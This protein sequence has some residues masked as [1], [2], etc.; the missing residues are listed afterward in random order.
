MYYF[1]HSAFSTLKSYYS[2]HSPRFLQQ[3]EK[4]RIILN[5]F[6][7]SLFVSDYLFDNSKNWHDEV[8]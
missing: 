6:F 4:R 7:H 1:V 3:L 5:S 2:T 8:R